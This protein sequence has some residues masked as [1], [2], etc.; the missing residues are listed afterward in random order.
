MQ[1]GVPFYVVEGTA[2]NYPAYREGVLGVAFRHFYNIPTW[3]P[4]TGCPFCERYCVVRVRGCQSRRLGI[5]FHQIMVILA[6]CAIPAG[7]DSY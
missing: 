3:L 1:D 7:A 5:D 4:M 6:A 2:F